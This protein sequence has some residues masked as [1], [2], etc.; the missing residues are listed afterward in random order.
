VLDIVRDRLNLTERT[1]MLFALHKAYKPYQV[2]YER[3]GKDSD[4]QHVQSEMERRIYT[5]EITELGGPMPK[6]DRIRRLIPWFEQGK[7]LLP[8]AFMRTNFEGRAEN[9]TQI[10]VNE[11]Y[12]AFP[13]AA[14][15]DMLDSLAR[16]CDEKMQLVFPQDDW[17]NDDWEDQDRKRTA[18]KVT[19]Y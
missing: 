2:G 1:G 17:A 15:D 19:G 10:F 9:L 7:I 14:H 3:Y 12:K 8:E 6:P 4:I 18:N 13:V 16:L 11:E 5:F